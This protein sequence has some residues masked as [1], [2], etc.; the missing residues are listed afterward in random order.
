METTTASSCPE[1]NGRIVS[2]ANERVCGACG[3][4]LD[5]SPLDR[6]PEWR[7]DEPSRKRTGA[8]LT[9]LRHDRGLSTRIGF[10]GESGN[11][12]RRK[13][14]RI[15]RQHNRARIRSKAERNR[16]NA[17]LSIRR[18]GGDL[19]VPPGLIE[20]AC[21]LF[22]SAQ[23]A[24]LVRGRSIEGFAAAT[25]YAAC[26]TADV[27]RTIE[28]VVAHARADRDELQ[29]AYDALNRE[30]GLPT[31]PIDPGEYVARFADR[32][33]LPGRV[34]RRARDFLEEA[35]DAGVVSGRN[36]SGVAA[37]CLYAA[38]RDVDHSLTQQAAADAADVSCVTVRATYQAI[39]E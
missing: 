5:T 23:S 7:R 10:R 15:R 13:L 29:A 11:A 28:E 18:L 39:T 1:C 21:V 16:M 34:E 25:I 32:L 14:R 6:G 20:R 4:V 24:D 2:E 31:G 19:G 9:R 35:R 38:A 36:P 17:N 12:S 27:A 37:G 26:R 33:D 30:L 22:E 8:P 3:L